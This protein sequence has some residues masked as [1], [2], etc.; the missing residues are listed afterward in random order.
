MHCLAWGCRGAGDYLGDRRGG[1]MRASR[2]HLENPP[3]AQ[4]GIGVIKD[5][6]PLAPNLCL[7]GRVH[8]HVSYPLRERPMPRI[9]DLTLYLVLSAAKS[10][11]RLAALVALLALQPGWSIDPAALIKESVMVP[12]RD[13]VKLDT[14]VFR[15]PD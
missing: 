14:N 8:V 11:L 15:P 3:G 13:G 12:M 10:S 5:F 7:R 1:R 2:H 4:V 9:A 6:S